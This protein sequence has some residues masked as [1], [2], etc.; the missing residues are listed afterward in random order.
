[1]LFQFSRVMFEAK[2]LLWIFM[3]K[4]FNQVSSFASDLEKKTQKI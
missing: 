3:K 2:T 4:L 1:M